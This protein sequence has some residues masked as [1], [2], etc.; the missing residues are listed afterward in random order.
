MSETR[1]NHYVPQW[2][3]KGFFEPG[4]SKFAYLDMTPGQRVLPDGR[5]I[6][7]RARF[8]STTGQCFRQRD[9]YSTFFGTAVNDEIERKLFGQIDSKGADA[10]RAFIGTDV[11][12]WIEHFEAFYTY[13]DAQKL[14]TPKGLDWLAAQYPSLHQNELMME[15]QGIRTLHC[16]IWSGGVREV[17]SAEESDVKFIVTDHPVTVYNHALPPEHPM[18]Q[19]ANEPSIALKASQTIF[20][21]N[22][23]FCLILTNLEYAKD[24]TAKPL[25]KR[26]FARNFHNG[27]VKADA[28]IRERKLGALEVTHINYVL[29]KRARRY[30]AAGKEEWL[31]PETLLKGAWK[32]VRGT[33]APPK[34]SLWG[35]GG[36][37]YASYKDGHVHYQDEF[38]RTEK[39]W[40]FLLKHVDERAL[41]PSS[42]C[43]CGSG[44]RYRDCCK[45]R[46][47]GLRPTWNE[48]SIRER[49]LFLQRAIVKELDLESGRNWADIRA[50]LTDEQI[51]RIYTVYA[52][53]WPLE[54][55]LLQLL[56]KPDG[57][58]RA[59]YT[60]CIHPSAITEFALG[61]SLYFGEVLIENPFLH[62]RSVN[63]KFS[64]VEHPSNYRQEFLKSVIL[65]LM[66]MPL[67]EAGLVNLYPD[68]CIFDHHLRD[69][70]YHM[71]Q[72]RMRGVKMA[73]EKEP[74]MRALIE[75]DAKR[76]MLA[77][78]PEALAE[79]L[80]RSKPGVDEEEV[81]EFLRG[82]EI[83]KRSDPLAILQDGTFD[84][85]EQGGLMNLSKLAP[86]F[87]IAVYLAQA[88][89][90]AIVTDSLHRWEEIKRT[91]RWRPPRPSRTLEQLAQTIEGLTFDF[92]AEPSDILDLADGGAFSGCVAALK[93]AMRYAARIEKTGTKANLEAGIAARFARAH[94]TAQ[95]ALKK[96]GVEATRGQLSCAFPWGGIQDNTV[97][98]LLLMSSS[99]HHLPNVPLA[100][101]MS[102][103]NS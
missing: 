37:I 49:N 15:M 44:K 62:A 5:V 17:V 25:E 87:E 50:A 91:M 67:V 77:L 45:S 14:R 58:M 65:F 68:P 78:P 13:I 40:D 24:P 63:E 47:S 89:G 10:V 86:N 72:A 4:H 8:S 71:A 1:N 82:V 99:E 84:G 102:V 96:S 52:A 83:L 48:R 12:D 35:F 34:N 73:P 70:M 30:I 43:G 33:L 55:D 32:D 29:K 36:E 103:P 59:V 94:A 6:A 98:R 57:A 22:R 93:E 7:H 61:A 21:L 9:L 80:K 39:P 74:R 101:Y 2:Y 56:P 88:T 23:D 54:T 100:F 28:L 19:G 42:A 85:G 18:C 26:T 60:G 90:S 76:G 20:P 95:S 3:Q 16:A 79:M 66:V 38:G 46:A 51:K 97:N 53:I 11:H 92:A 69:Q 75:E 81:Q 64:P 41:R 31:Y 27:L